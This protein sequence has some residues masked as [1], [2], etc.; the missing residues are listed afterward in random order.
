[1]LEFR[2]ELTQKY[3]RDFTNHN[4]T[5]IGKDYFVMELEKAGVSCYDYSPGKGRTP[6]KT[7][8]HVINLRDAVLP[9]IAFREPEFNRVLNW[10]KAQSITETKGV[11]KDLTATVDGFTYVF[12]TGGIHGSI[13]KTVVESNDEYMILDLDVTS[14]YPNLAIQNGLYPEHLG[15]TFVRIFRTL[16]EQR[17]NYD[18]KSAESAML[19]L[20]LNGV[21]GDSNNQFSLFYDPL[22]TM[23]ITLNGQLLLCL[24]AEQLSA[25]PS[26]RILQVNTDGVTVRLLRA[27]LAPLRAICNEWSIATRLNL[28][29][30]E[31]T[32]MCVRDVNNYL[33]VSTT[34]A[35]KRKGAYEYKM[36][37]HQNHS[38]LV[39][40]RVAEM[41]LIEGAN[42][43]QTVEAWP[44][45][46]D[47]MIKVKVPRTSRLMWGDRQIQGTSRVLVTRDGQPLVKVMP[48]LGGINKKGEPRNQERPMNQMS[49]WLTT[50]C[51][52]VPDVRP[53]INYDYYVQEVEKLVMGLK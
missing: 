13:E 46:M 9:W 43:R 18:K 14:Y 42:I 49:G 3:Q 26:C 48:P 41:A 52:D 10:L 50:V 25:I 27:N 24:L 22:F 16:F 8:R 29:D 28:E 45:M 36:G 30:V 15:E 33:A 19:K 11:F 20:A 17:K 7:P 44:D 40:P 37:W 4:D 47:F 21:Y 1:M 5:K 53:A 23:R 6:R 39:V 12:G 32:K 34:G 31:Y 51:N 38:A 2:E 35:V